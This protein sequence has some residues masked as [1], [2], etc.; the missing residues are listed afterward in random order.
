[1]QLT[2]YYTCRI[3]NTPISVH[4]LYYRILVYLANYKFICYE[5]IGASRVLLSVNT[6]KILN[7]DGGINILNENEKKPFYRRNWFWITILSII[8]VVSATTYIANY[9]YYK[10]EADQA[11]L[12]QRKDQSERKQA[13]KNPSLV[14]KYNS[15]KTG[16]NG[17]SRKVITN[18]LGNPTET[19]IMDKKGKE[20]TATWNKTDNNNQVI[21]QITFFK[22][23]AKSKSIQGLDIDRE[24]SLTLA[25][26]N[27]LKN[28]DNYNH[29]ISILGDP[30]DYSDING[31][32][33]LT[34]VSD[35]AE[36]DPSQNASI[37]IK[38]SDNKI[39]AKS[40]VNLK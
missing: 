31:I 25:D 35:L 11:N 5:N 20:I 22:N 24:N 2:R 26:F 8:I 14:A 18:L 7:I 28:G 37:D 16:K 23:I 40:Q 10:D 13:E 17:Y 27:K 6:S 12:E 9:S 1:M 3:Q 30:D 4:C 39:I 36:A 29:V 15:I 21:I 32:R 33:T 19:Q 38:L 34:Y